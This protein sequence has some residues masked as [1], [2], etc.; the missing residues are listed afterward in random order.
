MPVEL[1]FPESFTDDPFSPAKTVEISMSRKLMYEDL[2]R[3]KPLEDDTLTLPAE[4]EPIVSRWLPP[5]MIMVDDQVSAMLRITSVDGA[6][7]IYGHEVKDKHQIRSMKK[8]YDSIYRNLVD[9]PEYSKEVWG[10]GEACVAKLI[11]GWY[12]AQVEFQNGQMVR[13]L[14]VDLGRVREVNST[15][16][17]IPRAF[18]NKPILAIRMVLDSITFREHEEFTDW[19]P[20]IIQEELSYVNAGTILATRSK[21]VDHFPIPVVLHVL[22]KRGNGEKLENFGQILVKRGLAESGE[23]DLSNPKY[24]Q[25]ARGIDVE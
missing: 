10:H 15:D 20:T 2:A 11:N 24:A 25:H 14:Y 1:V 19:A 21:E 18:G 16:L 7:Q 17:R 12:R 22:K 13:V 8:Y 3:A 6:F 4:I 23:L 5:R 9:R